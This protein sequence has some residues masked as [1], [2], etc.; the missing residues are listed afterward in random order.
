[1]SEAIK[2][3]ADSYTM[4]VTDLLRRYFDRPE[5]YS[6][7]VNRL[8]FGRVRIA[9]QTRVNLIAQ[10]SLGQSGGSDLVEIL[11]PIS[12]NPVGWMGYIYRS[13]RRDCNTIEV[14]S[15]L[16]F[17]IVGLPYKDSTE[18][19]T[20]HS[21]LQATRPDF[22]QRVVEAISNNFVAYA[23]VDALKQPLTESACKQL[24]DIDS[25]HCSLCIAGHEVPAVPGKFVLGLWARLLLKASSIHREDPACLEKI[26]ETDDDRSYLIRT[27]AIG[28]CH[29]VAQPALAFLERVFPPWSNQA[30][31]HNVRYTVKIDPQPVVTQTWQSTLLVGDGPDPI[32]VIRWALNF[33][34]DE[35]M[36]LQQI[37][38]ILEQQNDPRMSEGFGSLLKEVENNFFVAWSR[39]LLGNVEA[40]FVR[41]DPLIFS[42]KELLVPQLK[43]ISCDK[44][45]ISIFDHENPQFAQLRYYLETKIC[46]QN[47][48][49]Y[50]L[51]K[52]VHPNLPGLII[53]ISKLPYIEVTQFLQ[54]LYRSPEV[55]LEHECISVR[56]TY[57]SMNVSVVHQGKSRIAL[58]SATSGE[59]FWKLE[60]KLSP[61]GYPESIEFFPQTSASLA[62]CND[63]FHDRV[64]LPPPYPLR[65]DVAEPVPS[66]KKS[67]ICVPPQGIE[68]N[69]IKLSVPQG[70]DALKHIVLNIC[71]NPPY[72]IW[73]LQNPELLR[74]RLSLGDQPVERFLKAIVVSCSPAAIFSIGDFFERIHP[75]KK[76]EIWEH[77]DEKISIREDVRGQ[78]VEIRRTIF[79]ECCYYHKD[80]FLNLQRKV[81]VTCLWELTMTFDMLGAPISSDVRFISQE[82][83]EAST[84]AYNL[85]FQW[86]G[87]WSSQ[88]AF[89]I[90]TIFQNT[91]LDP[92]SVVS[93]IKQNA[94]GRESGLPFI[95]ICEDGMELVNGSRHSGLEVLLKKMGLP[96]DFRHT[97]RNERVFFDEILAIKRRQCAWHALMKELKLPEEYP[98]NPENRQ[99][100]LKFLHQ[101]DEEESEWRDRLQAASGLSDIQGSVTGLAEFSGIEKLEK[102]SSKQE[103][104]LELR[105]WEEVLRGI[106]I[107]CYGLDKKPNDH[108]FLERWALHEREQEMTRF[109]VFLSLAEGQKLI[110]CIGDHFAKLFVG[111]DQYFCFSIRQRWGHRCDNV[112]I[113]FVGREDFEIIVHGRTFRSVD[114]DREP[115]QGLP[116]VGWTA[117]MRFSKSKLS[118]VRSFVDEIHAP[119]LSFEIANEFLAKF[120]SHWDIIPNKTV[121]LPIVSISKNSEPTSRAFFG[122]ALMQLSSKQIENFCDTAMVPF[123]K[124][125]TASML[126]T[127]M[128]SP[129]LEKVTQSIFGQY[130]CEF[131]PLAKDVR[132]G[133]YSCCSSFRVDDEGKAKL[134]HSLISVLYDLRPE[135][136]MMSLRTLKQVPWEI[137]ISL[138]ELGV[139]ISVT[140]ANVD[141]KFL[142]TA[143]VHDLERLILGNTSLDPSHREITIRKSS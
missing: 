16:F 71:P 83:V 86:T 38:C 6:L 104:L 121:L 107:D 49:D 74:E 46:D 89:N 39:S 36:R 4:S 127:E 55:L 34:F 63:Y 22:R 85:N 69:G 73:V 94:K 106:E 119:D 47:C 7:Q 23:I 5:K 140:V 26:L 8:E 67:W 32:L 1:M 105:R 19:A 138:D 137:E 35:R 87:T 82:G 96:K 31:H 102:K 20:L 76:D 130:A 57:N 81:F 61:H 97:V 108:L 117:V 25:G 142:P 24:L 54:K 11:T 12:F 58:R 37:R 111:A 15:N 92:I 45:S 75:A 79:S 124:G 115:G 70:E 48:L 77:H 80:I 10:E 40:L 118:D 139:P 41:P 28:M 52:T 21:V 100:F 129:F 141:E 122:P 3:E 103:R 133:Y 98:C 95:R 27:I 135:E 120:N 101:Y 84:P 14:I 60:I 65:R 125:A 9:L 116:W 114:A 68:L 99:S 66:E 91:E 13:L 33:V 132:F 2:R 109:L 64:V 113:N 112:E 72:S 131:P 143:L 78:S 126:N 134:R 18:V 128:L 42:S 50:F 93:L 136:Q 29:E 53:A 59:I 56:V 90:A 44:I 17:K 123:M 110:S 51:G 30:W 88:L 43:Y 62:P